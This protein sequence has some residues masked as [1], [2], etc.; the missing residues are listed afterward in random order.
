[1]PFPTKNAPNIRSIGILNTTA[2]ASILKVFPQIRAS[3]EEITKLKEQALKNAKE[4]MRI[5]ASEKGGTNIT[6]FKAELDTHYRCASVTAICSTTAELLSVEAA[7]DREYL[8]W[9]NKLTG[10]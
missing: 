6:N 10:L 3:N 2:T 1:M 7:D 8:P 4:K 9:D 5:A